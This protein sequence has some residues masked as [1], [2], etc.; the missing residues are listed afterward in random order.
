M[1][2]NVGARRELRLE[3]RS[4]V[5]QVETLQTTNLCR[6]YVRVPAETAI[7]SHWSASNLLFR[8]RAV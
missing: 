5:A 1:Q 7:S 2:Q 4:P 8:V 6:R 3:T